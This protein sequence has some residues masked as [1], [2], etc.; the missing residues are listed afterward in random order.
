MRDDGIKFLCRFRRIAVCNEHESEIE[1]W[2]QLADVQMEKQGEIDMN[3]TRI[4][5]FIN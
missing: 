3:P 4:A 5:Y 2:L 1:R